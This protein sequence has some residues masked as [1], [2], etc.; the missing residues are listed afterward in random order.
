[1]THASMIMNCE[2]ATAKD[3]EQG[4][5]KLKLY[6]G[7]NVEGSREVSNKPATCNTRDYYMK[8]PIGLIYSIYI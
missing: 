6:C 7:E 1:M 8:N 3:K 5:F 2:V 4:H